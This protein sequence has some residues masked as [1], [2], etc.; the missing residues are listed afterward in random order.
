MPK[1]PGLRRC[2][3]VRLLSQ[4]EL[5]AKSG[6]PQPTI[7]KLEGGRAAHGATVRKLAAA[8]EVE[9]RALLEANGTTIR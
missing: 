8:L 2:R 7:S 9:P 6:I 5:A 4:T 1:L 3:E